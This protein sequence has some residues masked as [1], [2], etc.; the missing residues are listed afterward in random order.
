[1]ELSTSAVPP[2]GAVEILGV[3]SGAC[4]LCRSMATD[5]SAAVRNAVGGEI[6]TYSDL[7]QKAFNR[8]LQRAEESARAKGAAGIFAIQAVCPEIAGGAAEV[9]VIGTAYR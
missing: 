3:V 1:M 6:T 4:V 2:Q 9:L 5:L 8:A 7:L